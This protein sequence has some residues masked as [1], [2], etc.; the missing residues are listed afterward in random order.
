MWL[1][2]MGHNAL[3]GMEEELKSLA[4]DHSLSEIRISMIG[5]CELA[6]IMQPR[7]ATK[8]VMVMD[9]D[10]CYIHYYKK[11]YNESLKH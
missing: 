8:M 1:V 9:V 3:K 4:T 11:L 6:A 7:H 2:S 10:Y 5:K